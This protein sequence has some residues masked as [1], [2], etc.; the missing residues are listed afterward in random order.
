MACSLL[1]NWRGEGRADEA[2]MSLSLNPLKKVIPL[3]GPALMHVPLFY[4]LGEQAHEIY[5]S[6]HLNID[7]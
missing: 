5:P 6:I 7:P 1:R 4:I 2:A 3:A